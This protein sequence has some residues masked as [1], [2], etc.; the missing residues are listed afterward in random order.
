MNFTDIFIQRPVL[1]TVVS[2]LILLA[3]LRSL[4]VLTVSQYPE[5]KSAIVSVTTVYAG[6]DA[7]LIQGFITTP[8]E[9]EIAAADG[10]D[11]LESSSLQGISVITAHLQLNYDPWDALTQITSK[12]NRVRDELPP[13]SEDPTIDIAIGETTADMYMSFDSET[14]PQNQITDYIVRVVQPRIESVEGVQTAEIIGGRFFAMRVWLDPVRMTALGVT[15][16]EVRQALETNNYQ[17]AVG[18]TKGQAISV[19]LKAA[20]DLNDVQQFRELVIREEGGAIVRLDDVADVVLGAEDYDVSTTYDGVTSVTLGVYTLPDAN[21]LTVIGKV[22]ELFPDIVARLPA[23]VLGHIPYDRTLYIDDA[24]REVIKT[25]IEAALIVSAVIFLFLGNIRSVM[26]PVIAIPVSLIGVA[27]LML[28]L[29][30]S[31]NLLTLLALVIAIG[32]VVDD[33][34][35]VVENIQRHIEEGMRPMQAA[36]LGARELFTPVIAMTITLVAV[37]CTDRVFRRPDRQPFQ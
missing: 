11:Y 31:I 20:T 16:R 33:A 30:Y 23:G 34:I 22:R 10:I 35:I 27:A 25:L 4:Q 32:L 7:D 12:V 37:L 13:G 29:G 26:I 15:P 24:I 14:L 28:V 36:L 8:L 3:G 2:L 17:A 9:R 1:A 6:A 18:R 21:T 19:N 5:S